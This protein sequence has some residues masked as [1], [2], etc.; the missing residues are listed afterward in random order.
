MN[1][2]KIAKLCSQ[3]LKLKNQIVVR[4]M[5]NIFFLNLRIK[6]FKI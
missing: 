2:F 5:E 1:S 4:M 6:N 3:N